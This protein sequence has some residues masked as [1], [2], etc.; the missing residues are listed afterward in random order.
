MNKEFLIEILKD[1]EAIKSIVSNKIQQIKSIVG[2]QSFTED[3]FSKDF[4]NKRNEIMRQMEKIRTEA[5]SQIKTKYSRK[6]VK[7]R[8]SLKYFSR[9][10]ETLAG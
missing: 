3:N 1:L 4:E 8:F 2:E 10:Y 9:Y 6:Y 7:R 5:F